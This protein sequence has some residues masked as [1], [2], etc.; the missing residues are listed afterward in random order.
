MLLG[1][2]LTTMHS[3]PFGT[4]KAKEGVTSLGPKKPK[5]VLALMQA[6]PLNCHCCLSARQRIPVAFVELTN[7]HYFLGIAVRK[8][9]GFIQVYST[10]GFKTVSYLTSK[11]N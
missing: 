9:L 8:M 10:T 4:K 6:V 5:K 3:D 7:R 1:R 11:Q 2:P